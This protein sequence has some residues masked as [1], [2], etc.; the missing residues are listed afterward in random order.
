[1][2]EEH[3]EGSGRVRVVGRGRDVRRPPCEVHVGSACFAALARPPLV[4][5]SSAFLP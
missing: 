5:W 3:A 2:G 4:E 1:M